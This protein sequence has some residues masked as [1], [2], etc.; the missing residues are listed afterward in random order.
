MALRR[1]VGRFS[2][3]KAITNPWAS[4]HPQPVSPG[5][6]DCASLL[7]WRLLIHR[8]RNE[9]IDARLK[10]RPSTLYVELLVST[11][12]TRENLLDRR[13][14]SL[15]AGLHRLLSGYSRQPP[16]PLPRESG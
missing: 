11:Y 1:A 13:W 15:S 5:G 8:M 10:R 12:N 9:A 2:G 16:P 4:I 14:T 3:L 7:L 6:V